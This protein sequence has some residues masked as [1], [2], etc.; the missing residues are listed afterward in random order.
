MSDT[1]SKMDFDALVIAIQQ[2]HDQLAV[3][4]SKAVNISLTLRNWFIG[5]YIADFELNGRDRAEYGE[6]LLY[7]LANRLGAIS[8]CNRRQLYD[9]LNFFR[10][11]P[12]IVRTV[13]AQLQTLLPEYITSVYEKVPTASAQ[14][15]IPAEKLVNS[16]SYSHFKLLVSLED[17]L[18]RT[19]YEENRTRC[20][21]RAAVA[22]GRILAAIRISGVRLL[23]L[24]FD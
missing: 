16:L 7:D 11:Y 3:Q 5:C 23:R 14:L 17:E 18:K 10:A 22:V 24:R 6:N 12:R 21:V 13:S 9:Y 1:N 4:A 2:V 20:L 15:V 19:F 8:N